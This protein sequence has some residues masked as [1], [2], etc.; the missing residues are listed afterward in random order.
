MKN[1]RGTIRSPSREYVESECART[2]S[3]NPSSLR[4][5]LS[6]QILKLSYPKTDEPECERKLGLQQFLPQLHT[7]SIVNHNLGVGAMKKKPERT[8]NKSSFLVDNHLSSDFARVHTT[9]FEYLTNTK[10][11][12][13][14]GWRTLKRVQFIL[15]RDC[16]PCPPTVRQ[17]GGQL[18]SDFFELREDLP[19]V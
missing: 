9:I 2:Y 18:S 5:C 19:R 11:R 4:F 14:P 15:E 13:Q 3:F 16:L 10:S 6:L 12:A 1:Y 8:A 7:S 17:I